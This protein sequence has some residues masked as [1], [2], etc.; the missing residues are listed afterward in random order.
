MKRPNP[1]KRFDAKTVR[2]LMRYIVAHNKGIF[3]LSFACILLSTIADIG[4]SIFMQILVDDYIA[5]LLLETNPVFSGLI[6]MLC[7]MA[8]VY[9]IG[10]VCT[11]VY[12]R[13]MAYV[14]Q[15]C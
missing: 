1:V 15:N 9:L 8:A 2:R 6:R 14:A 7:V 12:T 11:F 3:I 13:T 4:G 5:P 10:V